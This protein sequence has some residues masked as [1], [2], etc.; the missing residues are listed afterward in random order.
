MTIRKKIILFSA[1]ALGIF[2]AAVYL[3]SR[4]SLTNGFGRLESDSAE[5]TV[6]QLRNAFGN[7][8]N[9]LASVARDYAQWDATY[10]FI[11]S[12]N[13]EYVRANITD[14]TLKVLRVQ[15]VAMFNNS[16]ALVFYKSIEAPSQ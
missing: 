3:V 5:A 4:F 6:R 7:Q 12:D 10:D 13:A 2:L 16:G 11:P 15:Y 1:I 9:S 8:Q 14:D